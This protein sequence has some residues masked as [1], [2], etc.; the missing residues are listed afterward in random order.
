MRKKDNNEQL[1]RLVENLPKPLKRTKEQKIVEKA[2]N[3]IKHGSDIADAAIRNMH[4]NYAAGLLESL[5]FQD[6]KEE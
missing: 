3:H 2:L 1:A 5:L 6:D 4:L